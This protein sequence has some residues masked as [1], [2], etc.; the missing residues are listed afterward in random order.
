MLQDRAI[1]TIA[2]QHKVVYGLSNGAIFNDLEP[3]QTQISRS[4][5]YLT[6]NISEIVRDTDSYREILAG[7][8]AVLKSVISID[9]ECSRVTQRNIQRHETPLTVSLQQLSFL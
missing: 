1:L 7:T 4:H 5:H 3:L 8:R 2:N 9:L 6:L